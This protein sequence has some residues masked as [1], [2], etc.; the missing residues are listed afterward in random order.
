MSLF[1]SR[2]GSC[3]ISIT[4]LL[5][6]IT[7]NT[8]LHFTSLKFRLSTERAIN[9]WQIGQVEQRDW[10]LIADSDRVDKQGLDQIRETYLR[11]PSH[12]PIATDTLTQMHIGTNNYYACNFYQINIL[13]TVKILLLIIVLNNSCFSVVAIK[14]I[15]DFVLRLKNNLNRSYKTWWNLLT[16]F[17][18]FWNIGSS[19][20]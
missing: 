10:C 20:I 13:C 11:L 4:F 18:P 7:C 9:H 6:S 16:L 17:C 15:N 14:Q 12:S 2:V 5:L 3:N 1:S 8:L 19:K